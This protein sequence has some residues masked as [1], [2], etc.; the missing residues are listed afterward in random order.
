MINEAWPP[1]LT[2]VKRWRVT[3]GAQ[4][5]PWAYSKQMS[6]DTRKSCHQ[7][8]LSLCPRAPDKVYGNEAP[9]DGPANAVNVGAKAKAAPSPMKN[10]RFQVTLINRICATSLGLGGTR[11]AGAGHQPVTKMAKK[12]RETTASQNSDDPSYL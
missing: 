3:F 1:E 12:F 8:H 4:K 9:V 5:E 7:E 10:N 2:V 11:L 6:C